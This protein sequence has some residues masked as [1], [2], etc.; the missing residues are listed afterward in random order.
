MDYR[1]IR[2]MDSG[3]RLAFEE[4]ICQLARREPPAADAEFRRIEGA[5]GDGGIEAYWLL[6]DGKEIGFQAKYYL[7]AGEIDWANIDDSVKRAL[8]SHPTLTK[9]VVA[10][11]CDL[12]D[13]SGTKGGG[14]RG[15][16]HWETHKTKWEKLIP[17]GQK[18]EF[19]IWTAS[20]LT[21]R[22][23][24]PNAEGLKKYWFGDVEFSPRWFSEHVDLAVKSLDE[25]YHP[26]DHVEVGIERL[27]K[28]ILR[29]Q[30]IVSELKNHISKIA[31]AAQINDI[32]TLLGTTE[33]NTTESLTTHVQKLE[34]LG[35]K[36][37]SDAWQTWPLA[38]CFD[39][40]EK[41]S[42]N[43][44]ILQSLTWKVKESK[45]KPKHVHDHSLENLDYKLRELSGASYAFR[46]LLQDRYF[47][48][49]QER[50]VFLYGKAGTGKSHLLGSVAQQAIMEG[51]TAVL[52]LGQ[53]LSSEHVWSQV[54]RRLGLGDINPDAFLQAL[55]A[56][57]EVTG[58]RGLILIDALNEGAGLTLW[59][60]ELAE[61]IARIEKHRNLLLVFSCR[62]E[63]TP[64][65]IP[66][67]VSEKVPSF[68]IRGFETKEEQSRAARIYLGKRG[69]SQPNTPWL[70]AEFVNPLFL[71]S[72][73]VALEKENLK[74]F[75]KGLVGTKQV[76][77]FY[78]RSI[79]R[80]LSVGRDGSDE[81]VRPT[82]Q[83]LSKI[84]TEMAVKRRDYVQHSEATRIVAETFHAYP[85]PPGITWFEVLQRN[86]LF[87]MDPDPKS[88]DSDP[89]AIP[90]DIVRFSFQRLQDYLMAS[91]LLDEVK[92][93]VEAL[94]SGSLQFIHNGKRL[95]G[96]WVG[97]TEALSV[98]LPERFKKELMDVMPGDIDDWANDYSVSNAFI[99]SLRWRSNESFTERTLQLYNAFLSAGDDH[100]DIILQVSASA[101]HPWNAKFLHQRLIARDMPKRDAF[102]TNQ[103]NKLSMDEGDTAQRLI[104]WSAFEQSEQTDPEVQHLCAITLTWF[105]SSSHREIRDKATK[106]LTSLM[107]R[108]PALYGKLC[109]DFATV[110]DLYILERLHSAAY[111]ACCNDD[112]EQRLRIYSTIAYNAVFD[113]ESVPAS[114]LLRDSALG[115]IELALFK[116]CLP[117]T[118]DIQKARPPYKS[119][120]IRLSVTEDALDKIAKR[121]GDSQIK[122]SCTGWGGDF[123]SYEIQPRVSSFLKVSLTS[124]EPLTPSEKYELFEEEVIDH[125]PVRAQLLKLMHSFSYNPFRNIMDGHKDKDKEPTDNSEDFKECEELLLEMLSDDEKTRYTKEYK[126][127]FVFSMSSPKQL[128]HINITAAQRWIAKRAYAL[129]WTKKLFPDDRSRR[130]DY[131]RDRPLVE[132]IGKKYQWLALDELLCSLADNKWMSER[133]PHG[134][135]QYAGPLDIGFHRDIDP[136]ILLT[137]ETGGALPQ[138]LSI[139]KFEI[140]MRETTEDEVGKWPFDED[141]TARMADLIC[142]SGSSDGKWVVVHEHRSLSE[143]YEDKANR[144]HGLRKQEWRFLLPVI[145][146]TED[147]PL[148]LEYIQK[149]ESINVDSWTT[150]DSTD[151]G[152]L[153]EAP[154]RSTWDQEQ[155]S[156][157]YF[158]D[159]GE[160]DIAYPCFR[161]QWESHLD[162][163]L[164]EGAH[165][166]MPAPWLAH[167]LDLKPHSEDPNLYVDGTGNTRFVSGRSPSDGSHAYIDQE[168]FDSFLKEDGLA[169]VWVFVA[170]RGAW[171][172]G[173]NE[174]ASRRR[175]E[176]VIWH[177]RGK[178]KMACWND[179]WGRGNSKRYVPAKV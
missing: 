54:T 173:E 60:N 179:D 143:R 26:E 19:I 121:A 167:R 104:E 166:L 176:G 91:G 45:A 148:L 114:I 10:I 9:Y 4:L 111:G 38:E 170:E 153:R 65:V 120:V 119:K 80:N 169:C 139:E 15:W 71:R 11:P 93:P 145:V 1:R 141:P 21:D 85:P 177:E 40:V 77:S 56:A 58:K 25:R 160:V 20:D 83:A 33:T 146:R 18:V 68:R 124:P 41:I 73:C 48:N 70:A 118:I 67:N 24:H 46:S 156:S 150:R 39:C 59:R 32:E 147:E 52:I 86:G 88:R 62:T 136:T 99:E 115:I 3:Q 81:L 66:S 22:L 130:H 178:P 134:S 90:E 102:W 106:A 101:G 82:N 6:S 27:F 161:Y 43:V 78:L 131:S 55:S 42:E 37:T 89:F 105:C 47:R 95:N 125:C 168:L 110:D 75:P 72:A 149:Q 116:K 16:E 94:D 57:A 63:Y 53:H 31:N 165:S 97:L 126:E 29:N 103:I 51:R 159:L 109:D 140:C 138:E 108:N 5:G 74:W 127:R 12:T 154:W 129:G 69:I 142:R 157:Q 164:S 92:D 44:H 8:Q 122:D 158:H 117:T 152:F 175:S 135:R 133:A 128:P 17:P 163:S 64:Y 79:A 144:E 113:C 123:A 49:A 132:R 137:D 112:H 151:N 13:K 34:N 36:L 30:S 98:Q 35:L 50:S 107:L 96:E 100:F 174:N 2:G 87:R 61:F 14:K 7:R 28:V 172:G 23:T 155:W 76:F 162:A 84:A 171:P